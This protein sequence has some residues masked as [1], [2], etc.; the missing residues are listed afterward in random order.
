MK[1]LIAL[2]ILSFGLASCGSVEGF[3]ATFN[4]PLP[5]QFGG[6]SIPITIEK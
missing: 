5:D 2:S 3:S 1:R 4:V 6:G